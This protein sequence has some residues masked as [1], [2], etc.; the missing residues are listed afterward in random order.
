MNKEKLTTTSN[1]GVELIKKHEGF[2]SK[3][4]KCPAGVWTIGYGH[5]LN[6]KNTDIINLV[7]GEYFLR[8]DLTHAENTVK[9]HLTRLSQN[10]YDALVS[11]VFNVGSGNFQTSTLLRKAKV[12]PND[13]KIR[14]EFSRWNKAKVNGVLTPL[15]GLTRRRKDEADLYFSRDLCTE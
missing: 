4:Y 10:Q 9:K 14:Y 15:L 13:D 6:V 7:Q 3:A 1:K 5:T 11:F 8:Q 2:R 12:N